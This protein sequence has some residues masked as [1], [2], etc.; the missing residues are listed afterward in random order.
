VRAVT[1]DGVL[2]A[3]QRHLHPDQL[4]IVVVGDPAMVAAPVEA[5]TGVPSE[6]VVADNGESPT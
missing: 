1:T 4:R 2:R 6:I 5:V 3:A